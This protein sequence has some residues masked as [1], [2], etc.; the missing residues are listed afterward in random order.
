MHIQ[1]NNIFRLGQSLNK[2]PKIWITSESAS[3]VFLSDD[4]VGT[5]FL[6]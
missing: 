1:I 4:W 5:L 2:Y 6:A 3:V